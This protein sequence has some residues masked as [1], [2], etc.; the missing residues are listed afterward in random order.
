MFILYYVLLNALNQICPF[1]LF[2]YYCFYLSHIFTV[3]TLNFSN[4]SIVMIY[5]VLV[6][7]VLLF[8]FQDFLLIWLR[9]DS[10][11]DKWIQIHQYGLFGLD[12]DVSV[13]FIQ[14]LSEVS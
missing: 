14:K 1:K 2:L 3:S 4:Q 9:F 10:N 11:S 7:K 5:L 13:A 8:V 6:S 12:I